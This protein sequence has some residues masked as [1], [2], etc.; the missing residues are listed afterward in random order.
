[1]SQSAIGKY[2]RR[3][4]DIA[5]RRGPLQSLSVYIAGGMRC[6]IPRQ[7]FACCLPFTL[8]A[9]SYPLRTYS[10]ADGLLRDA[11]YK[12]KQDSRGFLWFGTV[13]GISRFDGYAFTNFTTDDGFPDRH[14]ND[15]L[16]TRNGTI[17]FAT[18]GGLARL[19]P[20]GSRAAHAESVDGANRLMSVIVPEDPIAKEINVLF[21]SEKGVVFAGTANGLYRLTEENNLELVDLGLPAADR[22]AIPITAILQD[23]LGWIWLG[24]AGSGL[25][26]LSLDGT[27]EHF[28]K[29]NGLPDDDVSA[30]AQDH[31]GRIW[32]GIRPGQKGGLCLLVPEPEAHAKIVERFFNDSDGLPSNWITD[33]FFSSDENF[34][35]GTTQ[36]LCRWQVGQSS[37][38][39]PVTAK[40]GLCDKEIWSINQDRDGNLWIG[41]ACG[42]KKLKQHG[43]TTFTEADGLDDPLANS[44]F[45]NNGGELFATFNDGNHRSVGRFG[46]ELF[47]TAKPTLP[48]SI[49]YFGW[50]WKQTVL[51]DSVGE[52]WWP[53]GNGLYRTPPGIGF[54]KLSSQTLAKVETGAKGAQVFRIFE[55]SNG[56]IWVATTGVTNELFR[57]DRKSDKWIDLTEQMGV[58]PNRLVSAFVEDHDG[59]LWIGSGESDS[60]LI[61]YREG[62]FKIFSHRDGLPDGWIRDLF[63][64]HKGRLW[65]ANPAVGLLRVDDLRADK[66]NFASYTRSEGLSSVGV[67]CVTEDEFGRI[68]VGT[69]RGLDRLDPDTGH[70]ENFTT[71]DGLPVSSVEVA[72]RDLRN[73]LWFATPNGLSR[74]TPEA[75]RERVPP[76]AFVT[77]VRLAGVSTPVSILGE[78]AIS[79]LELGPDQRQ[80]TIDFVGI[81]ADLGEKLKYEYRLGNTDWIPSPV[82]S[83]NF[84]N[85]SPG[86]YV[87]EVRAETEDRIYGKPAT[88]RFNIAAPIWQRPWFILI[89]LI[90]I[91]GILYFAYKYRLRRLIEVERMRTRIATD[92]HDDI[93][94]NLTKISI[95]SEVAQQ[96]LPASSDGE[97]LQMIAETSRESV[98]AMSDIVWAINPNKDSLLDMTRRMRQYA[99]ETVG[100]R[101]MYFE[102]NAPPA[103]ESLRLN[104]DTRRNIYLV[105]KESLNNIVRHS[106]AGNVTID[107]RFVA[108]ELILCIAD[109]GSGFNIERD[110][111]GNGLASMKK[112]A[113]ELGGSLSVISTPNKGTSITLKLRP[114]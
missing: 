73:D 52:W 84:A 99:Q 12:I 90:L 13:E 28:G 4:K 111:D 67:S 45:E 93:G 2:S 114:A 16:E 63:V 35:V 54:E 49:E 78:S 86:N 113:F 60:A 96:R 40:N 104:A 94:S 14:V 91:A 3:P 42:L 24:T 47:Q 6:C 38:C 66:L 15:F 97:L 112:R 20:A 82:R 44:I 43:F 103:I 110:F 81:G 107:L 108:G 69:G 72:Y 39:K 22:K 27:A 71:A 46:G 102:L 29:E 51:Q 77:G 8:T 41:T 87:F 92:L 61:R 10:V 80:V 75:P 32:V 83:V 105:F 70:I 68:Y 19:N 74:L 23:R 31:N 109:D 18:D 37:V 9:S 59:D 56:D 64:D 36:G 101:G 79:T 25:I 57:L 34:W 88:V 30:L 7:P 5:D 100:Q 55:Q 33:L 26:R 58:G 89:A 98:S 85:L 65:I 62:N 17:Y 76:N 11:V 106:N 53:T 48:S 95:L 1:M 21:E 50:G